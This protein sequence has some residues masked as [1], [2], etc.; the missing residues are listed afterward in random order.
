MYNSTLTDE[1]IDN[2]ESLAKLASEGPWGVDV[3]DNGSIF[4]I[5]SADGKLD[6]A[7]AQQ[8]PG[9]QKHA[10]RIINAKYI[11]AFNPTVT[12]KLIEGHRNNPV[13]SNPGAWN[14]LS[15]A[16]SALIE[17][18]TPEAQAVAVA[19]NNLRSGY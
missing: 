3:Q 5:S 8:I 15:D 19:W 1:H 4:E 2:L 11:G 12:R 13:V 16:I 17:S 7:Y 18:N 14:A 9:D 10:Q 6:I